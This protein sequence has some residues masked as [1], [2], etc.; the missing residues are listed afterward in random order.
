MK[1]VGLILVASVLA[2]S[3]CKKTWTCE[4]LKE[5][6]P[7]TDEQI[8]TSFQIQEATKREAKERCDGTYYDGPFKFEANNNCILK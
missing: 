1:K 5:N 2:L 6:V 3:S 4:C 7:A 8:T